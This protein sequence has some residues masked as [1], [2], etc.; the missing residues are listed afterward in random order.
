MRLTAC[1]LDGNGRE[2]TTE[3]K[4]TAWTA[5]L[6]AATRQVCRRAVALESECIEHRSYER[7]V[8]EADK[9][10]RE[11]ELLGKVRLGSKS[12]RS[13]LSDRQLVV[14]RTL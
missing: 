8:L 14:G 3:W 7:L 9:R 1:A 2:D 6:E 13:S 5:H 10:E 12:S 11:P 4:R